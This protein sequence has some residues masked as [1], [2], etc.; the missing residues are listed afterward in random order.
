MGT[1]VETIMATI[2]LASMILSISVGVIAFFSL[3]VFFF[4]GWKKGVVRLVK[5]IISVLFAL[6]LANPVSDAIAEPIITFI[7]PMLKSSLGAV[8]D[9]LF[10]NGGYLGEL[11][12]ALP[13][14][15]IAPIVFVSLYLVISF[16]LM[17]F[18]RLFTRLIFERG[19]KE[20]A[21][22]D[23]KQKTL[24]RFLALPSGIV[25]A[26]IVVAVLFLPIAGL[27]NVAA[28]TFETMV[29]QGLEISFNEIGIEDSEEA[30]E[31]VNAVAHMPVLKYSYG[32]GALY[33]N[34]AN[35]RIRGQKYLLSEEFGAVFSIVS[36]ALKLNVEIGTYGD[37]QV[38]AIK[39]I[40]RIFDSSALMKN[41]SSDVLSSLATAWINGE[42]YLGIPKPELGGNM[43]PVAEAVFNVMATTEYNTITND[44][45]TIGNVVCLFIDY[46]AIGIINDSIG[47][48]DLVNK[49]GFISD[50]LTEIYMNPRMQIVALEIQNYALV[51]VAE[52]LGV[53]ADAEEVLNNMLDDIASSIN[54]LELN[55]V[56]TSSEELSET[57]GQALKNDFALNGVTIPED[58]L[59]LLS[60][61]LVE[62]CAERGTLTGDDVFQIFT[63]ITDAYQAYTGQ[64]S[65]DSSIKNDESEIGFIGSVNASPTD[66][67]SRIERF[68]VKL[69]ESE[70]IDTETVDAFFNVTN[71]VKEKKI[72][73]TCVTVE[74]FKKIASAEIS[75]DKI[76]EEAKIIESIA[77]K[78]CEFANKIIESQEKGENMLM[79]VDAKQ[80]Q[81]I[82]DLAKSSSFIGDKSDD[83]L[84]AVV[85]SKPLK[86]TG[87]IDADTVDALLDGGAAELGNKL[88]TIQNTYGVMDSLNKED[89]SPE[90]INN[91]ISWLIENMSQ[92]SAKLLKSQ[93]NKKKLMDFGV[94]KLPSHSTPMKIEGRGAATGRV[95]DWG[96]GR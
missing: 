15:V 31:V 5:N 60:E 19:E 62:E 86:D 45:A 34:L 38:D 56:E 75:L 50:V 90:E 23:K 29:D 83:L 87:M 17:F 65:T 57:L 47:I 4:Q 41:I 28:N 85:Q 59:P 32:T 14:A 96:S 69:I 9:D 66:M 58:V 7:K 51:M 11:I 89:A 72:E 68:I 22:A 64:I 95:S 63:D 16:I 74:T 44:F 27:V 78:G 13:S 6:M 1:N 8:Y 2:N 25:N 18:V 67:L 94:R 93:L 26:L 54:S 82:V 88:E 81:E 43:Q 40:V 73:T 48:T 92:S 21:P 76:V 3:L 80:L 12:E 53:P 55:S 46:G 24:S 10:V 42:T 33:D 36:E 20:A 30:V 77:I 91:N 70:T 79:A 49:E 52:V 39:N 37:P 71:S 84:K 35:F 61:F